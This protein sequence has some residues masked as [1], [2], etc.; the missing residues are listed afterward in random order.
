MKNFQTSF[1]A[2]IYVAM[3]DENKGTLSKN[4]K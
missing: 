3:V 2:K 4:T 1:Q